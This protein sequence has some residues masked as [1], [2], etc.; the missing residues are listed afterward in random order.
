MPV[1]VLY[2]KVSL[3]MSRGAI[4]R[5]LVAEGATVAAGEILFEIE[6]DK[7]AVEV[8]APAAGV[9]RRLADEGAEVD[10]GATVAR[11]LAPGE[12][13]R[14]E[15]PAPAA[16][17]APEQGSVPV[18][19]VAV[20]PPA[21]PAPDRRANPNPTPLARRIARENGISLQGVVGTGP[22]GRVQHSD[23]VA[24]LARLSGGAPAAAPPV[25]A[26]AGGAL[27]A[28][29]LHRGDGVP[30]V[31]LHGFSAEINNWR[32]MFAG[33]RP[34]WATLALDLPGHGRSPRSVPETLDAVAAI[35]ERQ[36]V[37]E[38][39]AE[40][41]I[42]GH[43]FGG[44]VAAR[45][46]SRNQ[47]DVRGLCLFA[48][49]GLHPLIDHDFIRGIL[50]AKRPESLRPWLEHLVHDPR[51]ISAVFEQAVATARQD[52]DLTAAMEAFA[53]RFFP[54]GTQA[55]S[56]RDDLAQLN[57]PVRV[58]FGHQDRVLPFASTRGLPGHVGLHA[59]DQCGH[60]P[61]LEQPSL[62][63][64]LLSELW[65]SAV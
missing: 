29:W 47:L 23:V 50:R 46:A 58:I 9:L 45:V 21:Q 61:H 36:L 59:L 30:V 15:A 19:P 42:A 39:I 14:A 10:V 11:I 25:A 18:A 16:A 5:W 26:P 7:A 53:E 8:E 31:L 37:A 13:D 24:E 17:R 57:Q 48:P 20:P 41:V 64:R 63:L 65:R 43:S 6:N 56:I 51:V 52:Q 12:V 62:A 4:S 1:P 32:G 49:A 38:G 60:M 33:A 2:P 3:E 28:V 35:V 55:F 44:A 27:H 40:C 34:E 22:R 54:D